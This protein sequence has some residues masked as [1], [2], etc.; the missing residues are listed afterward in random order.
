MSFG[1][2][3]HVCKICDE[4]STSR[5]V[6]SCPANWRSFVAGAFGCLLCPSFYTHAGFFFANFC[7]WPHIYLFPP[8]WS[9]IICLFTAGDQFLSISKDALNDQ[10]FVIY[11]QSNRYI[12]GDQNQLSHISIK[13]QYWARELNYGPDSSLDIDGLSLDM[14]TFDEIVYLSSLKGLEFVE[15]NNHQGTTII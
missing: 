11:V 8:H 14:R 5:V 9:T 2:I 10:D 6:A 1:N 13:A 15:E 7:G 3:N 12:Q 4:F